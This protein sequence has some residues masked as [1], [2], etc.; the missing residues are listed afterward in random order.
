MFRLKYIALTF[1][2]VAVLSGC[3]RED[4]SDCETPIALD[5]L[6]YGGT[7][8]DIFPEKIT[9]VDLFVFKLPEKTL[10]RTFECPAE[11][12]GVRQG[13]EL[14][15]P[16]GEYRVVCWGNVGEGTHVDTDSPEPRIGEDNYFSRAECS[17][18][19]P[20]YFGDKEL[21]VP[22]TLKEIY[23]T[24][25][26]QPSHI[27]IIVKL[28]NFANLK[29]GGSGTSFP[30]VPYADPVKVDFYHEGLP[31]YMDFNARTSEETVD[32][33]PPLKPFEGDASSYVTAYRTHRFGPDTP[34]ELVVRKS[35]DGTELF[36][37]GMKD[38]IEELGLDLEYAYEITL[39]LRI[40]LEQKG[41]DVTI[42]VVDW[43]DED[44]LP[45][46]DR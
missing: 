43:D 27:N 24:I 32:Y 23:D 36:R 31:A 44:V 42:D 7:E 10:F 33:H 41:I 8:N 16:A 15:L 11:A 13:V 45:G 14:R 28:E 25:H 26:F 4:I 1:A 18:V 17:G 20:L 21:S 30:A 40:R 6:Y 3:I 29:E 5:F 46:F 9:R 35:S 37:K 12:L 2:L 38:I 22:L 39:E 34:S 19:D